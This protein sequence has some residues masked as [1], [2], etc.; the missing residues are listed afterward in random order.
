MHNTF[1][2]GSKRL[3]RSRTC[4]VCRGKGTLENPAGGRVKCELCNGSG[5]VA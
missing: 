5:E 1:A 2:D 3:P 4:G